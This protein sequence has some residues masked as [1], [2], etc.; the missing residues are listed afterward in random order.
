MR[1]VV[2]ISLPEELNNLVEKEV[3]SGRF[4]SKSEFIRDLLREWLENKLVEEIKQSERDF[5]EGRFK[6]LRSLADLK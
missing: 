1:K 2:N 3:K 6:R 4:A 5:K